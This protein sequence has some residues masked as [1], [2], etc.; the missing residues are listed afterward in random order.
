MMTGT[1]SRSGL[2]RSGGQCLL[3]QSGFSLMELVV[4]LAITSFVLAALISV[5]TTLTRSYTAQN[6][7]ADVQQTTRLGVDYMA[8]EIRMAGLNPLGK[9]GASIE[10]IAP[11]GHKLRFTM[12]LCDNDSG[13]DSPTPDGDLEDVNE[14]VTYFYDQISGN[15]SRCLYEPAN[16]VSPDSV[17]HV[18]TPKQTWCNTIIENVVPNPDGTPLFAFLDGDTPAQNVASNDDRGNIRTVVITLT[19]QEPAGLG[20]PVSR[21]YRT[22]VRCRN[23]GL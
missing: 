8:R 22:R 7:A 14:R 1:E 19:V 2:G 20:E 6:V 10:E 17:V 9:A 11:L 16:T 23:I 4:G 13:C 12:D 18:T 5:F 15:L 21:T 3:C